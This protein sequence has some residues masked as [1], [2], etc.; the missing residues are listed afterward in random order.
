MRENISAIVSVE[1]EISVI[2]KVDNR[3][4]IRCSLVINDE[5]VVV[6]KGVGNCNINV[7]GE[8]LCAIG[9]V[10]CKAYSGVGKLLASPMSRAV[11]STAV[12][13][14]DALFV[15]GYVVFCTINSKFTTLDAVSVL[16]NNNALIITTIYVAIKCVVT[17]KNINEIAVLVPDFEELLDEVLL[18]LRLVYR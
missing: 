15:A 1:V 6:T 11:F 9:T 7:T 17:N 12:K 2:C 13:A 16:T 8:A 18:K 10:I 4:L 14:G 5:L 3:L